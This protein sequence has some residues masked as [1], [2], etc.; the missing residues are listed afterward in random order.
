[1]LVDDA[2]TRLCYCVLCESRFYAKPGE[3]H[4]CA[5]PVPEEKA[6]RLTRIALHN[7]PRPNFST[8]EENQRW[9]EMIRRMH[10]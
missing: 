7:P 10:G 2:P 3:L 5:P 1:M 6:A 4:R 9:L 8:A